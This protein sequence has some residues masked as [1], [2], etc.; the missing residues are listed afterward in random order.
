MSPSSWIRAIGFLAIAGLACGCQPSISI[1]ATELVFGP[2]ETEKT[3]LVSASPVEFIF[4]PFPDPLDY[5][6]SSP[7]AWITVTPESGT[8]REDNLDE[9]SDGDQAEY[10]TDQVRVTIAPPERPIMGEVLVLGDVESTPRVIKIT[11]LD[12]NPSP[13]DS[14]NDGLTD[15]EELVF[16]SDPNDSDTDDDGLSDSAERDNGTNPRDRDSDDDGLG[17]EEEVRGATNPNDNDTDDDCILD[18]DD[19][20]PTLPDPEGCSMGNLETRVENVSLP[21]TGNAVLHVA[22]A[23]VFSETD[24]ESA[25]L[26]LATEVQDDAVVESIFFGDIRTFEP[27]IPNDS[28]T[29]INEFTQDSIDEARTLSGRLALGS[30]GDAAAGYVRLGAN[31]EFSIILQIMP[32]AGQA[33]G[34][35]I[36]LESGI[37][38]LDPNF[39]VPPGLDLTIDANGGVH[40][41]TVVDR[42][43]GESEFTSTA[44]YFPPNSGPTI[45]DQIV[46]T[47][48]NQFA[49]EDG[50][51]ALFP[52]AFIHINNRGEPNESAGIV[53]LRIRCDNVVPPIINANLFLTPTDTIALSQPTPVA[54]PQFA[55]TLTAFDYDGNGNFYSAETS[56]EISDDNGTPVETGFAEFFRNGAGATIHAI[57]EQRGT[58]GM[59]DCEGQTPTP[60]SQR[61]DIAGDRLGVL[62]ELRE[63]DFSNAPFRA[64]VSG[65]LQN[66]GS[67]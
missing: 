39:T 24:P 18:G 20:F 62:V 49:C 17:D 40:A 41:V 61:L 5:T 23:P 52:G 12:A 38:I 56:T 34:D 66:F 1:S 42:Q 54:E 55:S 30:D 35:P 67:E 8:L 36:T 15:E 31:G 57:S 7:Q 29:S 53:L 33:F 64:L 46:R 21:Q 37:P 45:I 4:L 63:C 60:Q 28:V 43:T 3:F 32:A 27:D 14:D 51:E 47:G 2:E 50:G 19:F 11:A 26:I 6:V 25:A 44:T 59:P 22:V 48:T 9:D 65:S 13:L 10:T 16:G 58:R